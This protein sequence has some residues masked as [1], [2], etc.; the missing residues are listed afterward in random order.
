MCTE[1]CLP[2]FTSSFSDTCFHEITFT[3]SLQRMDKAKSDKAVEFVMAALHATKQLSGYP[4]LSLHSTLSHI[5]VCSVTLILKGD[6][7]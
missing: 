6:S 3:P 5:S 2:N 7:D 4:G 1:V